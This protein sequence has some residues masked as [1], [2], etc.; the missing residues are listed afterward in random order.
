MSDEDRIQTQKEIDELTEDLRQL[1]LQFNKGTTRI[2]NRLA[3][4]TNKLNNTDP[5]TFSVGDL[6]EITN[7]YRGNRGVQGIVTR[8][9]KKQVT[10]REQRGNNSEYH[11]R[12]F[13]N[14]RIVHDG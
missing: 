11:T 9:T 10:L 6:V 5:N 7:N 12:S 2:N 3:R 4:L 8:V 1:T 14:V 13:K